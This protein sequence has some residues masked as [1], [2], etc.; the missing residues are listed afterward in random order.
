MVK[1]RKF[2]SPDQVPHWHRLAIA[3]TDGN[4]MAHA[5]ALLHTSIAAATDQ[6]SSVADVQTSEFLEIAGDRKMYKPGLLVC[7][8]CWRMSWVTTRLHHR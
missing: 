8:A 2:C 3:G 1:Y 7:S 4:W 5:I 6:A